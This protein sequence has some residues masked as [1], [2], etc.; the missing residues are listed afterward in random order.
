M[1]REVALI[2]A[3]GIKGVGKSYLTFKYAFDYVRG[4]LTGNPR[5]V[6]I[7][8]VNNEWG[9]LTPHP[10]D[11]NAREIG[12]NAPYF[13]K[14]IDTNMVSRFNTHPFIEMRR[15]TPFYTKDVRDK[16]GMLVARK[17]DEMSKED[18]KEV[19]IYV[20]KTFRGGLL[21]IEDMRAF[22]GNSV[23]D[24]VVSVITRN[25]HRDTDL[26]WHTQSTSRIQP[27]FFENINFVRFHKQTD[28][29]DRYKEKLEPEELFKITQIMVDN[30][31]KIGNERFYV[32]IDN[33]R[34]KI[35]GAFSPKMLYVAIHEYIRTHPF[36]LRK[37]LSLTDDEGKKVYN[38][39]TALQKQAIQY[40]ND[41]NGN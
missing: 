17:G 23:P 5:K 6:L 10:S 28:D 16:K 38:Y 30:E 11:E 41:Y 33:S 14:T 13:V 4:R 40:Y 7:F 12:W 36:V 25:R 31:H 18:F 22:F 27:V 32:T 19:L 20:N 9:K 39:K 21:I 15:I 29:V 24:D 37:Y 2:V 3:S 34:K 35:F 8:D 26:I 1:G